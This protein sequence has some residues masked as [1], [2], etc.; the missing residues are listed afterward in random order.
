M[1]G[2]LL[3]ELKN[4]VNVMNDKI[5]KFSLVRRLFGKQCGHY[6]KSGETKMLQEPRHISLRGCEL[7]PSYC[8]KL[9]FT[10]RAVVAFTFFFHSCTVH[11][12]TIKIFIYELTHNRV[13]LKEY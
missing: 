12:G 8:C 7:S 6:S 11:L 1:R 10:V 4:G 9:H 5:I 13:A 2:R 3:I